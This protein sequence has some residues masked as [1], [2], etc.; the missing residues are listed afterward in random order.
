MNY[1]VLVCCK[2]LNKLRSN[3][4]SK[5]YCLLLAHVGLPILEALFNSDQ[6]P[7]LQGVQVLA[8]Q[9]PAPS[10]VTDTLA[11]SQQEHTR[12]AS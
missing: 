4:T 11:Q 8:F 12:T 2:R 1:A 3:W 6:L 7:G 5:D 10:Q 9:M